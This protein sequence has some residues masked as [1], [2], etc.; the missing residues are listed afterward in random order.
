[1]KGTYREWFRVRKDAGFTSWTWVGGGAF[2]KGT[3]RVGYK[4]EMM[5]T[6][7]PTPARP[8]LS[9]PVSPGVGITHWPLAHQ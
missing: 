1:M 5:P 9:A 3:G 8:R 2:W 7:P 6:H 4:A